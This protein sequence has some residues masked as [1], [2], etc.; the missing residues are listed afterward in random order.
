MFPGAPRGSRLDPGGSRRR[1]L[2]SLGGR[3]G[4]RGG[5]KGA[6]GAVELFTRRCVSLPYC[7]CFAGWAA[8]GATGIAARSQR[9]PKASAGI[10]WRPSWAA[11]GSRGAPGGI[12]AMARFQWLR[13]VSLLICLVFLGLGALCT[14]AIPWSRAVVLGDRGGGPGVA[15][16]DRGAARGAPEGAKAMA[17]FQRLRCV[18]LVNCLVFL[19]LA[20]APPFGGRAPSAVEVLVR[21]CVGLLIRLYFLGL[22][23]PPRGC[24]EFVTGEQWILRT[25]I[26]RISLP[27]AARGDVEVIPAELRQ[28]ARSP[29]FPCPG[30]V[31]GG[32]TGDVEAFPARTCLPCGA[33]CRVERS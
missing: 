32:P 4:P 10:P 13:C 23:G 19:G 2:G 21:S 17:R 29:V 16:G 30:P 1:P 12:K 22:G 15:S 31:E 24:R 18:S 27:W 14:K 28:P 33:Y 5:P 26:A 3:R 6:Q 25:W 11:G 9:I 20:A 8:W 7:L